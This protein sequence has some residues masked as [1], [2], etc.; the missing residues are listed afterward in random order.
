MRQFLRGISAG[1]HTRTPVP[2]LLPATVILAATGML[3]DLTRQ[4]LKLIS[5]EV[6]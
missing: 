4:C 6:D 2:A 5:A 1:V 3:T